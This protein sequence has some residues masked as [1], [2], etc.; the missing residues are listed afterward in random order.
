ML[1]ALLAAKEDKPEQ[2]VELYALAKSYPFVANSRWFEDVVGRHIAAVAASLPPEVVTAATERGK[3]RDLETAVMELS[4]EI[5]T[6][7]NAI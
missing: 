5:G 4:G 1:A 7:S 3:A 6:E 2:A